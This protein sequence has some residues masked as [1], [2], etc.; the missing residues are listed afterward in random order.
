MRTRSCRSKT[1][2]APTSTPLAHPETPARRAR[3]TPG[4]EGRTTGGAPAPGTVGTPIL[5]IHRLAD[6]DRSAI[7][8]RLKR[9]EGQVKGVQRMI[10]EGR[11]YQDVLDQVAAVRAATNAVTGVIAKAVALHYLRHPTEFATPED[12][13]ARAMQALTRGGR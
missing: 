11:D 7:V 6:D 10:E 2:E 4:G 9:I 8:N 13:V 3:S 12:A 1:G 5:A